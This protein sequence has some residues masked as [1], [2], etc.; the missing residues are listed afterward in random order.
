MPEQQRQPDLATRR[1]GGKMARL[2]PAPPVAG[3][4]EPLPCEDCGKPAPVPYLWIPLPPRWWQA[5][6]CADCHLEREAKAG[7]ERQRKIR[8][9]AL[10]QRLHTARL[11]PAQREKT[12]ATFRRRPGTEQAVAIAR[13]Y[14]AAGRPDHGKGLMFHSA[15]NGAGKTHLALAVLNQ[16]LDGGEHLGLFIELADYLAALRASFGSQ[17]R[18][19]DELRDLAAQVDFLVLD[20]VGAAAIREGE[21]GDWVR[22]ELVRLLNRR[23]AHRLPLIVTTDQP[24]HELERRLGRRVVSRL[25]EACRMVVLTATDFRTEGS[26]AHG[27]TEST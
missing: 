15:Q 10:E 22:E 2:W 5:R 18:D 20:D 6:V 21:A 9:A 12:F 7:R 16:L 17:E 4:P 3:R 19:T 24:R 25:Y 26:S 8:R 1:R 13:A 27:D 11:G 23:L 14:A